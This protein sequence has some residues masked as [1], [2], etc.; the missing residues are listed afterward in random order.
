MG[1]GTIIFCGIVIAGVLFVGG[2]IVSI[3]EW[4]IVNG[5]AQLISSMWTFCGLVLGT[6]L[7]APIVTLLCETLKERKQTEMMTI[8][9]NNKRD[10]DTKIAVIHEGSSQPPAQP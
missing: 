9:E 2:V 4:N 6:A 5:Y 1:K 10:N 7:L 8:A 3:N